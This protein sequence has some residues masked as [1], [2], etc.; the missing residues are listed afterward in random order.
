MDQSD[1]AYPATFSTGTEYCKMSDLFRLGGQKMVLLVIGL[2]MLLGLAGAIGLTALRWMLEDTR[3][4]AI[5]L[6]AKASAQPR[7]TGTFTGRILWLSFQQ[8]RQRQPLQI[9]HRRRR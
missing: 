8:W 4:E 1:L 5:Y 7:R 9:E 3:E 2:A 6:P